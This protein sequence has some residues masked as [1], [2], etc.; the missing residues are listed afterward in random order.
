MPVPTATNDGE[1]DPAYCV[2]NAGVSEP[3]GEGFLAVADVTRDRDCI[4]E[5]GD[6][7]DWM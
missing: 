2:C 3:S 4:R 1:L 7:G 5:S 6:F